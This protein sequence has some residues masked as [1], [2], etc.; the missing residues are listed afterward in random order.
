MPWRDGP[1]EASCNLLFFLTWHLGLSN[2]D[3]L[4]RA[5]EGEF[6]LFGVG[7]YVSLH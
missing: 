2:A 7:M 1:S 6:F 3:K 4:K 5:S